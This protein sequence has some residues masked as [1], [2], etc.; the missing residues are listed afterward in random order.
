MRRHVPGLKPKYLQNVIV[1]DESRIYLRSKKR[2]NG[3]YSKGKSRFPCG[4]WKTKK[5]NSNSN[6]SSRKSNSKRRSPAGMTTRKMRSERSAEASILE[7]VID[8]EIARIATIG[9]CGAGS[10]YA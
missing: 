1:R 6:S 9:S 3:N 7:G 4:E 5:S 8:F 10:E 2:Y